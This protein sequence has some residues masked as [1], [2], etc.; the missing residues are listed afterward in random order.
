LRRRW[1]LLLVAAGRFAV[2]Q[3]LAC[4]AVGGVGCW[5]TCGAGSNGR[6]GRSWPW[7]LLPVVAVACQSPFAVA[8]DATV[9]RAS[10]AYLTA[11]CVRA[12][13]SQFRR[14]RRWCPPAAHMLASACAAVGICHAVLVLLVV[15]VGSR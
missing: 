10:W 13:V 3:L 9:R 1:C 5:V 4:G 2:G 6:V 8:P 7:L 14:W 15:V 11:A 12:L